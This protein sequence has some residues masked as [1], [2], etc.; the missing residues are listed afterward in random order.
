M[1][2]CQ[3]SKKAH[4]VGHR[5]PVYTVVVDA[6]GGLF[7]AGNDKGVVEWDLHG[8]SFKRILYPVQHSVYAL[9]LIGGDLLA[10]GQRN[11]EILL[12]NRERGE[13]VSK[14][15]LHQ[16]AVFD[17]K[18]YEQESK[19]IAASE[20]GTFSVWD[21]RT[22]NLVYHGLVGRTTLRNI[23]INPTEDRVVFGLKDGWIKIVDLTSFELIQSVQAHES[24]VTSVCFSP[25]GDRLLT[26][27]RDAKLQLFDAQG[28]TPILD[29]VPH[30]FAVY[31]IVFHPSKRVFATCSRDKNIK[32]WSYEDFRLFKSI[33]REKYIDAH[34][35]SVNK[36]V[37]SASG[38]Q[39][40]SVS[41][42]KL[43]MVWDVTLNELT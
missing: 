33:S 30:M 3:V 42:D 15:V 10:I 26:G 24:T 34:K 6:A 39:L 20:D 28:F 18:V 21:L 13:L 36:L 31:S 19:L 11:G 40:I 27:G 1:Y 16:A 14:F 41:D 25:D 4:L 5:N 23:A 22:G 7:T 29:F 38:D 37:W 9:C 8:Q 43:V 2:S 32:I 35:L 12:V 17:L